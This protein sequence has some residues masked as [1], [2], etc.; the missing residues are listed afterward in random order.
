[1]SDFISLYNEYEKTRD[2]CKFCTDHQEKN[3]AT[4]FLL[5]RSLGKDNLKDIIKSYAADKNTDG[6]IKTLTKK[7]F[8]SSVTV[9]GLIEYIENERPKQIKIREEALEGLSDVLADCHDV[10]C[11]IRNDKIEDIVKA[12]VRDKTLKSY[13][14]LIYKLDND[15]LPRIRKYSLWSYYNQTSN[16]II[17]LYFLKNQNVVPTLRKIH[18]VDFFIKVED[19][20]IPFDLKFTHI[21]DEYFDLA[22]QGIIK[23]TDSANY[24]DFC[25]SDGES[26]IRSIK[27]FYKEFKRSNPEYNL[28]NLKDLKKEDICKYLVETENNEAVQFVDRKKEAHKKYVPSTSDDLQRLEW[29]NYKYQGER[30]FCN[31]NRLFVFL[32]YIDKFVDGR[33]L[34]GKT[35]DIGEK[36]TNLLNNIDMENI[37]TVKYHY[38]KDVTLAGDYTAYSISTIY[39]E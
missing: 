12:F 35:E 23:N 10:N 16:D 6:D 3:E 21:S 38:D 34:K 1:M 26:E 28:P 37:H 14:D 15:V 22:S 32:A 8:D 30:L 17:E 24:D 31:N 29:W 18:D 4:R 19:D 9:C 13:K 36:I 2:V 7:A 25:I 33:E 27:N 39:S 5:I 11:G 20:L